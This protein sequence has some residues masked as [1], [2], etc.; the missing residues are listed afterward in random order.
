MVPA[1]QVAFEPQWETANLG[2]EQDIPLTVVR[3]DV[4]A[5]LAAFGASASSPFGTARKLAVDG[6]RVAV[7]PAAFAVASERSPTASATA[8]TTFSEASARAG[9][10]RGGYVADVAELAVTP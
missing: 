7:A 10:V 4:L 2:Q 6:V 5:H 1:T 8:A 3:A 9:G